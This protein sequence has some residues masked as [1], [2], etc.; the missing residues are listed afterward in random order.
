LPVAFYRRAFSLVEELRPPGVAVGHSFQTNGT[1]IDDAWCE[2]LTEARVNVGVSI[3][4]PR[5]LHDRNRV[6]RAGRG[7]FDKTV[8]G[9]RALRRHGVPFHVISVLTADSLAAPQEMFDFYLAEGIEHGCFNVEESEGEHRS[10]SFS[11]TG[12]EDAY[13]RFLT[14]FWRLSAAAPGRIGFIRE[15]DDAQRNVL[16]PQ[17]ANFFNQL[18]TPFAVTSMDWTGNI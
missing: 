11:Q 1:L 8:A 13:Y 4:G 6:T 9:I 15:L 16:R 2:F 3:D 12:I 14:E 5:H 18:A 17:E 7:T 10:A